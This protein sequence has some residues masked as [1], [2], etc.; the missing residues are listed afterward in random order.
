MSSAE[1]GSSACV[2]CFF[3]LPQFSSWCTDLG[4]VTQQPMGRLPS[5]LFCSLPLRWSKVNLVL[6]VPVREMASPGLQFLH[7]L[8]VCHNSSISIDNQELSPFYELDLYF[9]LEYMPIVICVIFVYALPSPPNTRQPTGGQMT[10]LH[11]S[12]PHILPS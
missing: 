10:G 1:K 7:H 3:Q 4:E 8:R 2:L 5:S 11:S 12:S 6:P 9:T